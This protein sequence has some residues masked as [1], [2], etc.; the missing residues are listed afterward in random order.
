MQAEGVGPL[1]GIRVVELAVWVAGPA[2]G[3]LLA[4]WGADVVKVEPP[5][6]EPFRQMFGV[7]AG[8]AIEGSPPFDLDNRGK[9]SVALDLRTEEGRADLERL[10]AVA[11]V[12]LSNQRRPALGRLGLAPDELRRRHPHLVVC[13]VSGYG[14]AGEE[15]DR[16]AFDIGAFYARTGLAAQLTPEGTDPPLMRGG[17]GDHMT[18]MAATGGI[19]AALLERA[20]TGEG[21]LVETSLLRTGAYATGWDLSIQ[22]ALGKIGAPHGREQAPNPMVNPYPTADGRW[23]WLIGVEADRHWPATARALGHEEWLDDERFSSAGRRRRN[24]ADLV[25]ALDEAFAAH[26]LAHWADALDAEGVWWA[27]VQ[28]YAE[29]VEDP[30]A[31]AAGV[32]VDVPGGPR[33]INTPVDFGGDIGLPPAGVPA[34]GQHTAEVLEEWAGG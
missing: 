13:H 6:G 27:P 9:R 18:A 26:D 31:L 8:Q 5:G 25:G 1:A 33:S 24:A 17:V 19:C 20:R 14:S 29:L 28:T 12:F 23:L 34:V 4:D 10:V 30:Q 15:V 11:D 3:G 7:V 2:A 22:L 32:V 21:Q 16:H